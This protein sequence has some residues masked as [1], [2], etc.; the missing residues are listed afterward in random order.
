[1]SIHTAS[2]PNLAAT[3]KP[4]AIR[5]M[6]SRLSIVR[7]IEP[8][9]ENEIVESVL[10]REELG[11]TG[12]GNSV[13]VPHAKHASIK[14]SVGAMAVSQC[15]IDFS[16]LDRQPVHLVFLLVSPPDQPQEHLLALE[17]ISQYLNSL[18]WLPP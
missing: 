5:E 13:A 7:A 2:L 11:S 3:N 6:V 8:E 1:V 17:R 12:I 15:G 18:H 16:S 10:N 14:S 9:F 4:G